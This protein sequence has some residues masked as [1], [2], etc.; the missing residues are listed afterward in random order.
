M[1]Q[2]CQQARQEVDLCNV[3]RDQGETALAVL[4]LKVSG[5]QD[6][7]FNGAYYMPNAHAQCLRFGGGRHFGASAHK[8]RVVEERAQTRQ[9]RT[10]RWLAEFERFSGFGDLTVLV[11]GVKHHQ[12][13]EIDRTNIHG[14]DIMYPFD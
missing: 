9:C 11:H 2:L 10:H 13:V 3:G 6:V 7:G 4:R 12:Q 14:V 5:Q 1:R 8:Q